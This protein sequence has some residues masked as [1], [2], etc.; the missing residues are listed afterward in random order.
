MKKSEAYRIAQLAVLK[1][2]S[3]SNE[4]K[5]FILDALMDDEDLEIFR[6]NQEEQEC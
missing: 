5:L 4:D 3:I 2:G 6:E 1:D